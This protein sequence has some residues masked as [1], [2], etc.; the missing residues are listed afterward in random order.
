M[1][2]WTVDCHRCTAKLTVE[3]G[4]PGWAVK[5][6]RRAGWRSVQWFVNS[7]QFYWLCP[8]CAAIAKTEKLGVKIN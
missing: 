8:G 5:K 7:V 1:K 4:Y 2:R 3:A 6:Y